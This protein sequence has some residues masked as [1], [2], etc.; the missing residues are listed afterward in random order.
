M[1]G[2]EPGR[3]R[4]MPPAARLA[5]VAGAVALVAGVVA[6]VIVAPGFP[7]DFPPTAAP[8]GREVVPEDAVGATTEPGLR[9][10][11][12]GLDAKVRPG[13]PAADRATG[14]A[15][16]P[17][18]GEPI[19]SDTG[20]AAGT[21]LDAPT[22]AGRTGGAIVASR[23]ADESRSTPD[24]HDTSAGWAMPDVAP[25]PADAP[26]GVTGELAAGRPIS[27]GTGA[28]RVDPAVL[29]LIPRIAPEEQA[30]LAETIAMGG[31]LPQNRIL[32]YYGHPHDP[33][34]GILGEYGMADLLGLLRDEAANYEAA[35]P[36]RPVIPAFEAIATVAQGW[37][38]QDGQ[39]LLDT[40]METLEEYADFAEA[41]GLLLFLD[42]QIGRNTVPAEIEKVRPLLERP[43]V[44]L[45]LDPEFAVAE[46]QAPG[47]HLGEVTA[48]QLNE[49][50]EILAGIVREGGL[51]PKILIVHQFR[52]DMILGKERLRPVLGVQ[53]A[54]ES[55]GFGSPSVKTEV[56][57]A[58]IRDDGFEYAGVKHFY[59][60]DVPLMTAGE[61]LALDPAPL[62]VIYQ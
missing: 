13:A 46:G 15:D 16:V 40:D 55:D 49:A 17:A 26:A 56:Y 20:S 3:G 41:N 51:P 42:L 35:D 39:Y 21:R 58:L 61:T 24:L 31:L 12:N 23:D 36:T 34:M 1:P 9:S 52:E 28:I 27:I 11:A 54:I 8:V 60:Q 45:A 19:L 43:Y 37:P 5:G 44:H 22:T 2:G 18:S 59:R 7:P 57:D 38:A 25:V 14:G 29:P 10:G 62:V 32:A 50:Q 48:E 53:L 6:G 4:R 47:T 30:V 33:N